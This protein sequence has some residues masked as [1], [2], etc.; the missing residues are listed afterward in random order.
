MKLDARTI[1]SLDLPEGKD[2]KI[3]FD[4]DLEGFGCRLRRRQCDKRVRRTWVAQYRANG[5]TRRTKIGST[6]KVTPVAARL[7]ARRILAKVTLGGDPQGEK[8]TKRREAARTL[9][10][11]VEAYLAT[12]QQ[13]LRPSSFRVTKL[14][15]TGCYFRTLH[16]AGVGEIFHPDIAARIGA[17]ERAHGSSTAGAARR[18]LSAFFGW[19]AAEGLLGR[20]PVNPVIGTRKPADPRPRDHVLLNDELVAIWRACQSDDYGRIVCLLIL[21]GSRRQEIGGMCWSELDLDVGAWR[22]PA[23]RSK[24]HQPHFVVMPAAAVQILRA[25]PQQIGR[26]QLFGSRAA[27]GFTAWDEGKHALDRRL[28][29]VRP[30]HLHD[31]RRTLATRWGDLGVQPHVIEA[32]LNHYSGHRRGVAGVYNRSP[33]EREVTAALAMWAE[34]VLALVEGRQSKVVPLRA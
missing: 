14:Y 17:I 13:E 24:N 23:Q 27:D 12:K 1:A 9:R 33:Y 6:E 30:W 2:D 19:A 15:L 3:Y 26:D 32:A 21:L 10:S 22:L 5:R 18:A 16:S 8:A 7:E 11:A 28:N 34:H 25:V 20:N 31:V 29:G 4:E